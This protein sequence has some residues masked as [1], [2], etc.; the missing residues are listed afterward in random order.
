MKDNFSENSEQYAQFRPKYPKGTIDYILDLVT[1]KGMAWDCATGNG[2][3]AAKLAEYFSKVEATDISP[4]QIEQAV[5]KENINYTIQPAEATKFSSNCFDLVTVAQAIHWFDFERF[6][7]EVRRTLKP[8]GHIAVIG[9]G[10]FQSNNRT[11]QVIQYL[12]K[13]LLGS[14]WDEERKYLDEKYKKIPFPFREIDVPDQELK[15]KWQIERLIGYLKTWSGVKHYEKATGTNP[16]DLIIPDL[17]N[18]FGSENHV[19]FPILTRI[20][21]L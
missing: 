13:E 3:L 10:L 5:R 11:N 21:K 17:R 15:E 7:S 20:G 16:V 2:Q 19:M 9:Y 18:S 6:Y 1:E 8:Q 4:Q 14:Y 12:Y